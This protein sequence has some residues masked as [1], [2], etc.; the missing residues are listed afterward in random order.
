MQDKIFSADE[1][2]G[3]FAKV[4]EQFDDLCED[5]PNLGKFI[6]MMYAPLLA[7]QLMPASSLVD[8][9]KNLMPNQIAGIAG[10]VLDEL[11]LD[12][13]VNALCSDAAFTT[14]VFTVAT[15]FAFDT[16][17]CSSSI[18]RTLAM[19]EKPMIEMPVV[20]A[21]VALAKL[22]GSGASVDDCL[23]SVKDLPAA[24]QQQEGFVKCITVAVCRCC[25]K[26]DAKFKDYCRLLQVLSRGSSDSET[27]QR[28]VCA[29]VQYFLVEDTFGDKKKFGPMILSLFRILYDSEVVLKSGFNSW[30]DETDPSADGFQ[31]CQVATAEFFQRI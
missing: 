18:E 22:V 19:L 16:K 7:K 5:L 23:A 29:G 3:A 30:K 27:A 31:D 20:S 1:V 12:K 24:T 14:L 17:R 28:G 11:T 13:E 8:L 21:A 2:K 9:S 25:G 10:G 26:D 6:G 4:F 15:L